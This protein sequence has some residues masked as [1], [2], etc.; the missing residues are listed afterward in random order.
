MLVSC[1]QREP[2]NLRFYLTQNLKF[3]FY[4]TRNPN[5]SKWNIG[6]VGSQCK[7]LALAMYISFFVCRF[8]LG[9]VANANPISSGI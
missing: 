6:C 4:P 7:I 5:A 1:S 2:P 8:H 3:A 9:Q